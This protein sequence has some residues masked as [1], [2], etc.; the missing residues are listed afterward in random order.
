MEHDPRWR[1]LEKVILVTPTEGGLLAAPLVARGGQ[2]MGLLQLADKA[3]GEF[4]EDDE[5]ILVQLSRLASI[6]IENA[7]LYEELRGNDR[8][9][10]EFLAMLAHELRN[11]LAAIGNAVTAHD[12]GAAS[13]STSSGRWT[14]SPGR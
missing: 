7:R 6:A 10:D 3:E 9:K 13:R 5:A 11:P 8:R 4:T 12:A 1:K 2:A 14:S